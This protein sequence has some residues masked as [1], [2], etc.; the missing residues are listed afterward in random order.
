V[1]ICSNKYYYNDENES[2]GLEGLLKCKLYKVCLFSIS[3][4]KHT[5]WHYMETELAESRVIVQLGWMEG[6]E[7]KR[8]SLCFGIWFAFGKGQSKQR[9]DRYID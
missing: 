1:V 2:N 3:N 5:E 9:L 8:E 4:E 6:K 7:R